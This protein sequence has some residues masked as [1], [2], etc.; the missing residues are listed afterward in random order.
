MKTKN[1]QAN[2]KKFY[3]FLEDWDLFSKFGKKKFPKFYWEQIKCTNR[4]LFWVFFSGENLKKKPV[5]TFNFKLYNYMCLI[6]EK[7][8]FVICKQE[9]RSLEYSS[10]SL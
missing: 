4:D 9:N 6:Q 2:K 1:Y 7:P 8:N 5:S 3:F 10:W